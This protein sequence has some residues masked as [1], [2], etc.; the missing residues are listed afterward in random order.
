MVIGYG[1]NNYNNLQ[2]TLQFT[3]TILSI[4]IDKRIRTPF[5]R[6]ER[7]GKELIS[8]T[9][10]CMDDKGGR[11]GVGKIYVCMYVSMYVYMYIY[12]HVCIL[13][14]TGST[15]SYRRSQ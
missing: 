6:R 13:T 3:I 2:F 9:Y 10:Y 14:P 11:E 8:T 1:R 15:P 12:M 5:N 4:I 7:L